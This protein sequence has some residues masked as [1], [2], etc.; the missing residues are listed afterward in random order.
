MMPGFRAQ[1]DNTLERNVR[2]V[3]TY[4][5]D[6]LKGIPFSDSDHAII[7]QCQKSDLIADKIL[8]LEMVIRKI[9]ESQNGRDY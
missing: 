6:E 4:S 1:K 7:D 8:A 9:E 3:V 5:E 2:V